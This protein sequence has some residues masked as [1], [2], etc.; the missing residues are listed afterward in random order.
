MMTSAGTTRGFRQRV[1]PFIVAGAVI[2]AIA[3][4][5]LTF[6]VRDSSHVDD[7][8][9][10]EAFL[11]YMG[12]YNFVVHGFLERGLLTDHSLDF[13]PDAPPVYYTHMPSLPIIIIGGLISAG[14]DTLPEVRLIMI[15]V[16]ILGLVAMLAFF[17]RLF[18][19]WHG[20]AAVG[21][22]A[23]N[24]RHVLPMMDH[25]THAYWL[26]LFF[27]ALWAFSRSG[28][29]PRF[30]WL[31]AAC[32]LVVSWMNYIQM[33]VLIVTLVGLWIVRL[34]GFTLRRVLLLAGIACGGVLVHI[35]QNAAVLGPGVAWED[36]V[37]SIGNR[38]FG[39]PAREVLRAFSQENNLIL[40]GVH[41]VG[42]N[43]N[44]FVAIWAQFSPL[45]VAVLL[46]LVGLGALAV[47]RHGTSR[48]LAL[49]V[50]AA[51]F[52]A[53]LS[54]YLVLPA[55]AAAYP[56]PF[57]IAV[58][59]AVTG[60]LFI[61]EGIAALRS[62]FSAAGK[63]RIPA[64][65]G[66]LVLLVTVVAAVTIWQ[67][68]ASTWP[69]MFKERAYNR[70][71]AAPEM[72]I[73]N[74]FQGEVFWTN[75]TP[76]Q[77]A[78]FTRAPAIGQISFEAFIQR[79]IT[80]A[81]VIPVNRESPAWQ[82]VSNPRYF[83]YGSYHVQPDTA[84]TL[85]EFASY[86]ADNYPIIAWSENQYPLIV[87]ISAGPLGT[88][89]LILGEAGTGESRFPSVE[90]D[91]S[92]LA[93]SSTIDPRNPA[94]A[95]VQGGTDGFWH[96]KTP[97]EENPA[98]ITISLPRAAAIAELRLRPRTGHAEQMW[99][100]N[101]AVLQASHDGAAWRPLGVLGIDRD[102]LAD[103]WITFPVFSS[104]AYRYYRLEVHDMTFFS[105]GRLAM[106]EVPSETV[107]SSLPR[108]TT[109]P[110]GPVVK[111]V[112]GFDDGGYV[113]L[114]L[115]AGQI[116]VSSVNHP[117]QGKD[118]LVKPGTEGFWHL[119]TPRQENPAWLSVDLGEARAV[120]MVR[121]LPRSGVTKNMWDGTK[122]LLESS[123][124]GET[125]KPL[126][127]LA[128]KRAALTEDWISFLLPEP[129]TH[130]FYRLTISD[131]SFY[132]FARLELCTHE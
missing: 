63:L 52:F 10:E 48:Y 61:G 76:H 99:D 102:Y 27:L 79:D 22:L 87:D 5:A 23:L 7:F 97:R 66:S 131:M 95:L 115:L 114:P 4:M 31:A 16:F 19:P 39:E 30:L 68:V 57:I 77:V 62:F 37:S 70:D 65:R 85:Q 21:L 104:A 90:L 55:A 3:G 127:T 42:H 100:G 103:G 36:I 18:T 25:T 123:D 121:I 64:V 117:T 6:W 51:F 86:L 14:V 94:G 105:L 83:F 69:D 49:R 92:M 132:S 106:T 17:W 82:R 38:V 15:A 89:R 1:W 88:S 9:P 71:F 33:L 29:R 28:D 124:D 93:V 107:D 119:K 130:R 101:R 112:Q 47:F 98:W 81:Y 26:G 67:T 34:P 43:G 126:A 108:L 125:W 111:G 20:I 96:L 8:A 41:S 78:Y 45:I 12:G 73:L 54:F 118:N 122:A 110:V 80:Q 128:V 50:L 35:I 56:L 44:P 58:P 59:V 40:W 91:A 116:E 60:G 113:A 2:A 53:A 13:S 24:A 46:P 129:E 109:G 11:D 75:I 120:A 32:V 74:D 72:K 84:E